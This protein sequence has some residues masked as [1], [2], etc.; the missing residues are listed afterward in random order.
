MTMAI[1]PAQTGRISGIFWR[2]PALGL[3]LLL[4]GPLMWFGIVYLGSLLTLL[5]QSIYTFDDF[6]MSVTSDFTLAN[7]RALFNPANY[8][9][10]VRTLVMALCVTLASALLALPMAWYMARYTSGK[11][12]AFFY[13]AV[14]LPMW[15]SYIVKAYAWVLLLAK[16]GVAQWF[17]GHLGLEGALNALLSVPAVGGNTL[18][19]SGLGRFLVFVYIWLPFMIL[20][21]QAALERI[22][23]SLLQASADLGA[24]PR[25]TFRYVV[26]PLAIPGIAAGSIFTFSLTLGDF[27]VPQLV[28]PPGY[29][30]GNMVYSQQGAIGNMPMAA[31]FT[32]VPIVLI[33]LYLA[34]VKRLGAFDAL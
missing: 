33:A 7:L 8:D 23:G 29:F 26:L 20:P 3:F 34:F 6:T 15:A 5:W 27:I 12:K 2:R 17:L 32:L 25:Q 22:P 9:I 24:A 1:T 19:T 11:M 10:I 4:L 18:S 28:G 14:M 21:V 16:D 30:T 31:A 13:I